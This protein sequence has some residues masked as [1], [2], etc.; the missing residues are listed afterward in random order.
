MVVR[1]CERP[2]Q[3]IFVIPEERDDTRR[4]F[5]T[6]SQNAVD[7]PFGIRTTIDV[8]AKEDHRIANVYGVSEAILQI[9]QGASIS[10][11]VPDCNRSHWQRFVVSQC[12]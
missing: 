9:V 7:A 10:V 11:H 6:K 3:P 8:I 4:A 1:V 2:Q 5:R 12:D